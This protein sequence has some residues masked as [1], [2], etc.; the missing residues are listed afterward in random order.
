MMLTSEQY[1]AARALLRWDI[2]EVAERSGLSRFTLGN[3]ES[4]KTKRLIPANAKVLRELFEAAGVQFLD[5][6][7]VLRPKG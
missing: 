7:A 1:R 2:Q 4:G 3:F 5:G 6:G